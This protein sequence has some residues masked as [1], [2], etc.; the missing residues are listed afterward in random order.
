[1]GTSRH[2]N[3]LSPTEVDELVDASGES[4]SGLRDAALVQLLY[5]SGIR[6]TEALTLRLHSLEVDAD[7]DVLVNVVSGKGGR[8]GW[9]L[10]MGDLWAVDRWLRRR[11][12]LGLGA[13]DLVFCA[14][15]S[16]AV[17]NQCDR[18]WAGRM[19]K[20]LARRASI[21]KR[22]HCHGF[23]HSHAVRLYQVGAPQSAIQDQLR[24]AD[25]ETT[26]RYLRDLGCIDSRSVLK[27]LSF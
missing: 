1:M 19:V 11:A 13:G 18:S 23:R 4:L 8:Q 3:V 14:I 20:R 26:R 9:S 17:G 21:T 27:G 12:D 10:C 7:G 6:I 5:A 22:V 24:H 2:I 25:P 15:S 16:G